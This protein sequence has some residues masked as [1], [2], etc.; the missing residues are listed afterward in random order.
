[1]YKS[2]KTFFGLVVLTFGICAYAE[3]ISVSETWSLAVPPTSK[4]SVVYLL[5]QNN[6]SDADMLMGATTEVSRSVELHTTLH[7]HGQ[8]K[9]HHHHSL[10]IPGNSSFIMEPGGHH[11]MLVDIFEPLT[12]GQKFDLTLNFMKGGEIKTEVEVVE[13]P[14]NN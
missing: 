3:D 13:L 10:E 2:I 11:I 8:M 6:G 1:M 7:D 4:N 12:P 9:M 14:P 5:I